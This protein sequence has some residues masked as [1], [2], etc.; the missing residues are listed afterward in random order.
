[1]NERA[2][3][4]TVNSTMG[5][6]LDQLDSDERT[7]DTTKERRKAV[8]G[9]CALACAAFDTLQVMT[10]HIDTL[11]GLSLCPRKLSYTHSATVQHLLSKLSSLSHLVGWESLI[12]MSSWF[13]FRSPGEHALMSSYLAILA[14]SNGMPSDAHMPATAEA[15]R[16]VE[17]RQAVESQRAAAQLACD[18]L[19]RY[20]DHVRQG[21]WA[22]LRNADRDLVSTLCV[23]EKVIGLQGLLTMRW[24]APQN[25]P[26]GADAGKQAAAM[27]E[28]VARHIYLRAPAGSIGDSP[29]VFVFG[30][31]IWAPETPYQ[32]ASLRFAESITEADDEIARS[33][34]IFFCP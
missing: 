10:A 19:I 7:Q 2:G 18:A 11:G 26:G 1:M 34:G 25:V 22:E 14:D 24:F 3:E 6:R 5:N 28:A 12:D 31:I 30:E 4:H 17:T 20:M 13:H 8:S 21:W 29:E 15:Q 33:L 32:L 16:L 27:R 9:A 23:L